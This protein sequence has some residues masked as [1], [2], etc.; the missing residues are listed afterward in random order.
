M[1]QFNH[2]A[3]NLRTQVGVFQKLLSIK[4]IKKFDLLKSDLSL[5]LLIK[6]K[7][8]RADRGNCEK[9]ILYLN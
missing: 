7:S 9:V 6:T 8:G 5:I 1:F 2:L 4:K 3:S